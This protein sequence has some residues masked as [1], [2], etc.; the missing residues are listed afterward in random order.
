[1]LDP[2]IGSK[3][4]KQR[5]AFEQNLRKTGKSKFLKKFYRSLADLNLGR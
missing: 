5:V 4:H 1:V 2:K 3:C